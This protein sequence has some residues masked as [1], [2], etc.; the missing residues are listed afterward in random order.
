MPYPL[1]HPRPR[2]VPIRPLRPC[3]ETRS[4][5]PAPMH[6]VHH[7]KLVTDIP[8]PVEI[9]INALTGF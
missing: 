3:S 9:D 4:Y 1:D 8:F 7:D 2:G 6:P 5:I